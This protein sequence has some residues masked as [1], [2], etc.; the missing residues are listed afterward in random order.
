MPNNPLSA[1]D[2]P[3]ILAASVHD[4]K[5]SLTT[6]RGLI[7]EIASKQKDSENKDF[8]QLEF[9]S[10]RI[11]NSLIQ[12]LELYKIDAAQFNLDIDEHSALDILQEIQA[13]QATLLQL[14][15]LQLI[16]D[17]SEALYCY[18]DYHHICNALGSVLNNAQRYTNTKIKLS[19]YQEKDYIVFCI[20]DDGKGYPE[21]LL[22]IDSLNNT[23][24]D[25]VS[26]ST[27][28]GIHFASKIA[29]LH[30]AQKSKGFIKIDNESNL[31]GA[32][33]RLFLP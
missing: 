3:T 27:G 21:P 19:A 17:C 11:N 16:I 9:E 20:E 10:N 28:L 30:T 5:N 31:G 14:N 1:I 18:C 25:W 23:R 26:S 8:I 13:Q 7:G 29:E 24:S 32:R 2:F 4:I 33:F 6:V 15:N 12:L 22:S